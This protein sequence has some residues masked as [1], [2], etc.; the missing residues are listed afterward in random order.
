MGGRPPESSIPGW[1]GEPQESPTDVRPMQSS[2]AGPRSL[3]SVR[4]S[5]LNYPDSMSCILLPETRSEFVYEGHAAGFVEDSALV[6]I[7]TRL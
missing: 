7:G 1:V 4:L 5:A 2:E 3:F 6:R